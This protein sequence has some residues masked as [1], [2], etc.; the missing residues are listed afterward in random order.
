MNLRDR[1]GAYRAI[2]WSAAKVE[3]DQGELNPAAELV[4]RDLARI[5]FVN[6]TTANGNPTAMAAAE[7]RRQVWLH[8]KTQLSLTDAQVDRITQQD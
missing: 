5:C 8:I 3:N 1:V 2:F 6:K 7:G 4:L